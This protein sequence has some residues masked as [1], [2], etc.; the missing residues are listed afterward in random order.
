MSG[1]KV[2][3]LN[4]MLFTLLIIFSSCTVQKKLA[5]SADILLKDPSIINAHAGISIFEP[6]NN[7]YWYNYQADNYFVPASNTKIPTC[8]AAMKYLGDSLPA[9]RYN[10]NDTAIFL[11][12]C[13]DPT[14]LHPGFKNQPLINFLKQSTKKIFITDVNWMDFPFGSGWSWDDYNDSYAAERSPMP[15]YGNVIKWIQTQTLEK[16][17]GI[18]EQYVPS[19]FSEPEVNWEVNFDTE[20]KDSAFFV[21]RSRDRNSYVIYQGKEKYVEQ[22]VPFVADG[23]QTALDLL[24]DTIGKTIQIIKTI[25]SSKQFRTLYSHPVDSLL[26]PLMYHSDNFFAEQALLMIGNKLLGTMNDEKILDTLLKSD[27][28][29]L[30]QKPRWVDGSGLSHYN[31]FSPR[32]FVVI[33]NKMKT[34]FG[35]KRIQVILPT[36]GNGTM[37]RYFKNDSGYIYAKT[38]SLSGVVALSGYLYTKRGKLLIFSILINNHQGNASRIRT[39]IEK[40]LLGIRNRY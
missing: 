38:G 23:L 5:G 9:I 4:A 25:P 18:N 33:L 20:N 40:F 12:P 29:D 26:R 32:D 28:K 39:A 8:Y 37:Q 22:D 31:L 34:E 14:L 15:V 36:G 1:N 13:G 16:P 19:V 10:E 2:R 30:P 7:K 6:A 17:D 27:L 35:M 24:K 3:L 11:V 21:R